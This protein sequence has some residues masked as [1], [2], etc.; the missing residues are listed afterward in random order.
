[1]NDDKL[2][3]ATWRMSKGTTIV[4]IEHAGFHS[5]AEQNAFLER[6]RRV[7]HI[8]RTRDADGNWRETSADGSF[9]C[10]REDLRAAARLQLRERLK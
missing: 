10:D 4:G 5:E 2:N 6:L 9:A 3:T 8:R 1:M 7:G